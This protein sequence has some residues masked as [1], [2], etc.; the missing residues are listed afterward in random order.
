MKRKELSLEA[1]KG[2]IHINKHRN[3]QLIMSMRKESE[4]ITSDREETLRICTDFYKS[5]YSQTVHTLESTMKSSL[6]TEEIPKFTGEEVERAITRKKRHKAHGMDEITS[7]I[8]L[9]R[10]GGA[11]CSHLHNK[12]L[13]YHIKGKVDS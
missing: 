6:D 2:L 5:L 1:R 8:K 3:E 7:D 4:E 9:G 13:Q 12:H 11:K 10:G